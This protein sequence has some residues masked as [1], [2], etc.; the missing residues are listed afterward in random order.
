MRQLRNLLFAGLTALLALSCKHGTSDLALLQRCES[1]AYSQPVLALNIL[2]SIQFPEDFSKD[3]RYRYLLRNTQLHHQTGQNV[4]NDLQVPDA[5]TYFTNK[6]NWEYAALSEYCLGTILMDQAKLNQAMTNFQAALQHVE[7][8]ESSSLKGLILLN[9]G[10]LQIQQSKL[11]QADQNIRQALSSFR[12][13]GNKKQEVESLLA[14][15][16]IHEQIGAFDQ[17]KLYRLQAMGCSKEPVTSAKCYLT[18][19][20]LSYIQDQK[21]SVDQYAGLLRGVLSKVNDPVVQSE[22]WQFL[23]NWYRETGRNDEANLAKVQF[24]QVLKGL[25]SGSNVRHLLN[26]TAKLEQVRSLYGARLKFGRFWMN[27]IIVLF[28]CIILVVLIRNNRHR[29]ALHEAEFIIETLQNMA[30]EFE[31]KENNLRQLALKHFDILKKVALLDGMMKDLKTGQEKKIMTLFNQAVYENNPGFDWDTFF[32]SLN[33]LKNGI[34]EKVRR[35]YPQLTETEYR[36]LILSFTGLSN[37]ETS[38]ILNLSTNTINSLRTSVRR[39]LQVPEYGDLEEFV[40]SQ[41]RSLY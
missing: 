37:K 5:T 8:V 16:E 11:P 40:T 17:S 10:R 36:I 28:M 12:F 33:H 39:K 38:I 22:S 7:K 4:A 2:D 41:I 6:T 31:R 14:L 20:Q 35:H 23:M 9:I 24:D 27:G 25:V 34:P 30:S 19:C 15:G 32:R 13:A 29:K 21:D 3:A 26:E 18:L 1:V